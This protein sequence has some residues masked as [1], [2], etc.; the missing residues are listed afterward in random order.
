MF[1]DIGHLLGNIELASAIN[2]YRPHLIGGFMDES[3]N[4]LLYLDPEQ[5]GAIAILS[6]CRSPRCARKPAACPHLSAL[7]AANGVSEAAR[8]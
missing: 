4:R 7:C 6:P 8:W 2:D 1:L 3:V 5:E